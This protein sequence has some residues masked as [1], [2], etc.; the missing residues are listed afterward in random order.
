MILSFYS[1]FSEEKWNEMG[2]NETW[3]KPSNFAFSTGIER[4]IN[5]I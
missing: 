3:L 5:Q 1:I 4:E 2:L